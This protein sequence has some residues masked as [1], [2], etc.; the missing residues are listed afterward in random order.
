MQIRRII[1]YSKTGLMRELPFALGKV[2][3]I[4][5]PSERGKSAIVAII[6]YCLGARNLGVPAGVIQ[7]SV[8]WYALELDFSGDRL[9]VARQGVD[10]SKKVKSLW[11]ITSGD[12]TEF[13]QMTELQPQFKRE[14]LLD[15]ISAKLGIGVTL[16]PRA[17]G[18]I[19]R[20]KLSFRSALIYSLQKQNE[21]A[22]PDLF[23]HRQSDP[24]IAQLIRDTLPYYLGAIN[25]DIIEKQ[26]LLKAEQKRIKEL[27]R[28]LGQFTSMEARQ[29]SDA[30]YL[31]NE[32]RQLNLL[33][34]DSTASADVENIIALLSEAEK[35]S[36][37][38]VNIDNND[39]LR[40]LSLELSEQSRQR[41]TLKKQIL[42]MEGLSSDQNEV[43]NAS[44]EQRR[45]LRSLELA[46]GPHVGDEKC[47]LCEARMETLPPKAEALSKSL[48][49][50][51]QELNFVV[52][53]STQLQ[54]ALVKQQRELND[55]EERIHNIRQQVAGLKEES[56]L[57]QVALEQRNEAAR[58]G[59]MIKMFLRST[60]V[61]DDEDRLACE[62]EIA[63]HQSVIDSIEEEIDF[64]SFKTKT[65]TFLGSIG[66]NITKW[67]Q[68][69]K[70]AYSDGFLTFD[71]RGPSLVNE[72]EFGTVN[73]SRFGS[74][75]NWVWYHLL[76]H[77]A[78]HSWFISRNRPTPRFLVVDQPSQV[79]FPGEEGSDTERD[80]DEVRK[81]YNWLVN[82]TKSLDGS[83]QI[84]LTDHA[85][86]ANDP[87]F[88]KHVAHDWWETGEALIPQEW[89]Q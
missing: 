14:Q 55:T 30:A 66:N 77:M 69:L 10:S 16:I 15:K 88:V 2:N 82:A 27:Q 75:K 85:R 45:R 19:T 21:I 84:I 5:G 11:H 25:E 23:F 8:A 62:M 54:E 46:T 49:L 50:L 89:I 53:D 71:I 37:A 61:W 59:G 32:A 56:L 65:A 74:G 57:V 76:G 43:L 31:L 22:N 83:F 68:D 36:R 78:L 20:Q 17:D 86:F 18:E 63:A 12:L 3:I 81:I 9:F 6:D 47:P 60:S 41:D 26:A 87:S 24:R 79:Y 7:D 40:R 1:L 28:K 80:M 33:P 51:D 48:K 72:T 38:M 58:V 4:T 42:S 52:L 70:L 44:N 13:P 35:Q 39:Q 64:T 29:D 34:T 67:A 73:F